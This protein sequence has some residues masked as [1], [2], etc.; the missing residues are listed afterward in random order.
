MKR[1][2][3][4]TTALATA[5]GLFAIG[6]A[7][8]SGQSGKGGAQSAQEYGAQVYGRVA[9]AKGNNRSSER[10]EYQERNE[11]QERESYDDDREYGQTNTYRNQT[12]VAQ[13]ASW[14]TPSQVIS[15]VEAKGYKVRE[16]EREPYGYEVE[17]TNA[18]GQ[19]LEVKVD[20]VTGA[21][22]GAPKRDD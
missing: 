19:R 17:M 16:I 9:A 21:F 1:T 2:I 4:F 10:Y 15:E 7:Q 18:N 13:D 22:I 14:M 3:L 12:R 8:A 20:P 6:A 11:Y 5:V